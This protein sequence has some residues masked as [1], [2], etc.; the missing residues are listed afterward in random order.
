M[1]KKNIFYLLFSISILINMLFSF[2]FFKANFCFSDEIFN[3]ITTPIA[4]IVAL[5][6]AQKSWKESNKNNKITKSNIKYELLTDSI[7]KLFDQINNTN[8]CNQNTFLNL[9]KEEND[10]LYP[11]TVK[12]NEYNKVLG[13]SVSILN[14]KKYFEEL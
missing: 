2:S 7:S 4:A 1:N 11:F 10:S 12:F 14:K 8:L 6:F 3:N 13:E 9:N 5:I